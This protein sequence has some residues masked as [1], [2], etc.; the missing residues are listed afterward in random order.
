MLTFIAFPILFGSQVRA[1]FQLE[2]R[3]A[4]AD[5]VSKLFPYLDAQEAKREE[6][7]AVTNQPSD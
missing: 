5:F 6:A 7:E 3:Q 1:N 2:S 4:E